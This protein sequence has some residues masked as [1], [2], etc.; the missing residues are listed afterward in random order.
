MGHVLQVGVFDDIDHL[1]EDLS[2]LVLREAS[3]CGQSIEELPSFT[4][5]T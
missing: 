3:N 5:A 2:R 4:V 1:R